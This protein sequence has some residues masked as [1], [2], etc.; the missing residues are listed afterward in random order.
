MFLKRMDKNAETVKN[1][2]PTLLAF[3]TNELNNHP[4]ANLLHW[5]SSRSSITK[6]YF[7]H[8]GNIKKQT[9]RNKEFQ[10][11][12]TNY[13]KDHKLEIFP[14]AVVSDNLQKTI[15]NLTQA[16]T[17][18]NLPLNTVLIDFD[19]RLKI[20]DLVDNMKSLEKNLLVMRNQSGFSDFKRVDV[21]W[22]SR[23]NGNLMILLAYLITHSDK[24]LENGAT[25]RIYHVVRNLED[26]EQEIKYLQKIID[27]SRIENIE[28]EIIEERKKSIKHLINTQSADADLA[29][30]GLTDLEGK[31]NKE[32]IETINEFTDKLKVSLIVFANDKIDFRVN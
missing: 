16:E 6:M 30:I 12:L 11:N 21:W 3:S 20:N 22:S 10:R 13:V 29:I 9:G 14:R 2:R 32:V 8:K 7:L 15:Y 27:Q 18:G 1:W 19:K 24:W 25:I 31:T 4:I 17:I 23:K 28:I 26:E 5:I